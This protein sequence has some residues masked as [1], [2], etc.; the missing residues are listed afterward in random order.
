MR[1]N[2]AAAAELNTELASLFDR[3]QPVGVMARNRDAYACLL[4]TNRETREQS[5]KLI[6]NLFLL[7][8]KAPRCVVFA[9][10]D[11]H[12][13]CSEVCAS[14]AEILAL[15]VPGSVCVVETN[16]RSPSLQNFFDLSDR[17][18]LTDALAGNEPM[19]HYVKRC[20]EANL[21]VLP[22]GTACTE[23]AALLNSA[24]M[25]VEVAELRN[26]FEYV[27]L[28]GPPLEPYSDALSV[29]QLADGIVLVVEANATRREAAMKA[30]TSLRFARIKI[31]G[32]VL[33]KRTFPIPNAL[34]KLL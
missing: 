13:G 25:K 9:G 31:L 22:A 17:F 30:V 8:P 19:K 23:P 4:N 6:Q 5:Q 10:I 2:T 28:D 34:F 12:S 29:A 26:E 33:N 24:R 27:I 14:A 18:G 20:E 7:D 3:K 1:N 32:A 16:L 11:H 15:N 21:W